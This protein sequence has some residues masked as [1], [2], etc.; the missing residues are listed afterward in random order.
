MARR[1]PAG[2]KPGGAADS[3]AGNAASIPQTR[4]AAQQRVAFIRRRMATAC[5]REDFE[6]ADRLARE[7]DALINREPS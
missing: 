1:A 7:L 3:D 4:A 6:T 2:G 5:E